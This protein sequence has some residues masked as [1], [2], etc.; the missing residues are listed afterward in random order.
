[1]FL[2][3]SRLG[4]F[5]AAPSSSR[6][7]VLHPNGAPL[8][9][10]LRGE[11]AEF[12]SERSLTRLGILSLSTCVGLRYGQPGNSL[13]VFLGSVEPASWFGRSR[14]T[15]LPLVLT[16][17]RICLRGPPTSPPDT[18]NRPDCLSS[19]VTPSYKRFPTGAGI[20]TCCP[21][22]TPFGLG[23]GPD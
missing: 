10:R 19:C 9:P 8:L 16:T 20:L 1:V 11:F 13:E 3:N 21:S 22:P 14:T 4:Q 23:L 5:T 2:V 17:S 6:R 18:S 7:E 15:W 12:L